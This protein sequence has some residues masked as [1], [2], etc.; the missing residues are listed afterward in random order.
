MRR[1][2]TSS[3]SRSL[4][5]T[6][7][8]IYPR[9]SAGICV[10]ST[11]RSERSATVCDAARPESSDIPIHTPSLGLASVHSFVD[12]PYA[13]CIDHVYGLIASHAPSRRPAIPHVHRNH[14]ERKS[15]SS[16]C[17]RDCLRTGRLEPLTERTPNNTGRLI[18]AGCR[19]G[20]TC[21][22]PE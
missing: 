15:P 19:Y 18:K 16:M 1:S 6:T 21:S 5:P 2:T 12:R 20:H 22:V 11:K 7:D 14:R 9:R 8:N 4:P 3:R 17:P 10:A 13:C